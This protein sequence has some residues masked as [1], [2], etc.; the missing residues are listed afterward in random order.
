VEK[1]VERSLVI[2]GIVPKLNYCYTTL[3]KRLSTFW[4]LES[5]GSCCWLRRCVHHLD[6]RFS[7][8]RP[9]LVSKRFAD[10]VLRLIVVFQFVNYY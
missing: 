5:S 4:I 7:F 9:G 1:F 2:A 6:V 8:T 3:E 10:V